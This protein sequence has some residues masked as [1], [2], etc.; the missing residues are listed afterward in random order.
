[1]DGAGPEFPH[2]PSW[3]AHGKLDFFDH[4]FS[5]KEVFI[6]FIFD[7]SAERRN[8]LDVTCVSFVQGC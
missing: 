6:A 2:V 1:M 5:Y 3:L 8:I 7:M 4:M